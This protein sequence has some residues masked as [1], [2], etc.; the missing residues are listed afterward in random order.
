MTDTPPDIDRDEDRFSRITLDAWRTS[1]T[2]FDA[3]LRRDTEDGLRQW[4]SLHSR[5][6]KYLSDAYKGRSRLFVP[7]T[8]SAITKAEAQA[9]EAFFSTVDV[10]SFA[11]DDPD[12]VV[13]VGAAQFFQN[14]VQIRLT[15]PAP[16]GL[17]WF[18]TCIGAYQDAH[19]TGLVVSKSYWDKKNDRPMVDLIPLENFRFDPAADWRDP[20]GT[21]PY[22][23]QQIP[24]Y[25]GEIKRRVAEGRW[26]PVE[27][28]DLMKGA[29][30]P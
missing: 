7:K 4:K 10:V 12:D 29:S 16:A 5:G 1:A 27:D 20:C 8:R 19:V 15:R 17:P 3:N 13:S 2:Y 22:L 18:L 26:L 24:M 21:S 14:L 28:A 25:V 9:A 30:N 11:P 23:I 6:S